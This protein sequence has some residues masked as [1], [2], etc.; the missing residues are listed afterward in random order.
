MI[1]QFV[2]PGD[3]VFPEGVTE[4][5][6]DAGFFVSSSRQGTIFRGRLDTGALA[7]W[8]PAGAD[9]RTQALGMAVDERG[10]LIVCGF[11]T[12]LIFGYD[13][14]SGDLV[15]RH[16]VDGDPA[17]LNDVC[18][19]NGYAYVTD[20]ERPVLWRLE[21]GERIG[22]PEEWL[23][24]TAHGAEPEVRHY[25]NGIVPT[26]DGTGLLVVGQGSEELWRVDVAARSARRVD[27]GG[28]HLAGDGM[29]WVDDVLYVCDNSQDPD[30]AVRFWLTAVRLSEG[31]T[32]GEVLGR[33]ERPAD[34]TPTTLAYRD[35]R[36]L[37]VNAQF[38]AERRGVAKPPFTVSV[39][40][41]PL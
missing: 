30:G 5:T 36:L 22:P 7:Q 32:V 11:R 2:L 20:S 35:G 40:T 39:V 14:D 12:G 23:D 29:V 16:R 6:D 1:E 26:R 24:L 15:A 37:V 38:D 18:V 27:L 31:D 3:A 4:D 19:L 33:W 13:I 10:R 41:P 8:Q 17:L 28:E 34:D 21:L 25:L 9:G